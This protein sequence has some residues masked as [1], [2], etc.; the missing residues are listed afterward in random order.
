MN[1]KIIILVIMFWAIII[2]GCGDNKLIAN[3][4]SNSDNKDGLASVNNIKFSDEKDRNK[5]GDG[6]FEQ[7][8]TFDLRGK[9]YDLKYKKSEWEL[10]IGWIDYYNYLEHVDL[11]K[12][13]YQVEV[14]ICEDTG[15]IYSIYSEEYASNY[16]S[17][18]KPSPENGKK[19]KSDAELEKLAKEYIEEYFGKIDYDRYDVIKEFEAF[20]E[21]DEN[22]ND[23]V[24]QFSAHFFPQYQL[25]Y[26]IEG[27]KTLESIKVSMNI[28]GD[29]LGCTK[30]NVGEYDNLDI[31][32]LLET[33][34]LTNEANEVAKAKLKG[35]YEQKITDFEDEYE[36]FCLDD[37]DNP[38]RVII[39]KITLENGDKDSRRVVVG[40]ED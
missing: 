37:N 6:E 20:D 24:P 12:G 34:L 13:D 8:I 19:Q 9:T 16:Y 22:Q 14:G 28:Y 27:V 10:G 35:E 36:Y 17:W 7:T 15:E 31:D 4:E 33:G 18:Y 3:V 1:K 30:C 38:L 5:E 25:V 29:F 32:Y 11:E 39:Y 23:D 40:I 21:D 2:S 26:S